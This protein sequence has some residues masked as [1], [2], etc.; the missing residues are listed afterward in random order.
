MKNARLLL[1]IP[2]AA[3]ALLF[4]TGSTAVAQQHDHEMK[5][6]KTGEVTFDKETKVGELT[7]KPG[8][9]KFQHRVEGSNHFVHFTEWT[10]PDTG[11]IRLQTTEK[12]HPGEVQCRVESLTKKVSATTLYLTTEGNVQRITKVE[13]EGENIAHLL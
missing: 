11:P 7:L 8:R 6:G 9:Y 3:A 2:I 13:V 12:A 4:Y 5:V 10:R 1:S